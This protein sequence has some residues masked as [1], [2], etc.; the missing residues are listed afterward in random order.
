MFFCVG[1]LSY[2]SIKLTML[3]SKKVGKTRTSPSEIAGF[4]TANH[5]F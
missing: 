4:Q 2:K 3:W 1:L 5:R